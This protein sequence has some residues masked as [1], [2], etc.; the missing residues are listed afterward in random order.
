MNASPKLV[1]LLI[2]AAFAST[3][4][5]PQK[6]ARPAKGENLRL[7]ATAYCDGGPTRSGVTARVG[8]VAADPRVLPIGTVIRITV[9]GSRQTRTYTVTDTGAAVKG[10][11]VDIFRPSCAAAKRFGKRRVAA[12]VVKRGPA[13]EAR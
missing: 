8:M 9:P 3:A 4:A 11:D 12:Y 10:N 2:V 6:H 5:A 13:P 1:I 7:M